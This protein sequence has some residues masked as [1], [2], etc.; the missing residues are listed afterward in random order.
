MLRSPMPGWGIESEFLREA[1]P[2]D[3]AFSGGETVPALG[4]RTYRIGVDASARAS[5]GAALQLALDSGVRVIDTAEMY[6][7]GGAEGVVGAALRAGPRDK[8]FV[9]TT[10][11]P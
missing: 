7:D 10:V 4:I 11:S 3:V 9:A 2:M 8:A 6:A 5:H 1:G